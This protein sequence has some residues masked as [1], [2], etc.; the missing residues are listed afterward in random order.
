MVGGTAVF[1][2]VSGT[3]VEAGGVGGAAGDCVDIGGCVG[4]GVVAASSLDKVIKYG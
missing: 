3:S 1:V 2:F 4:C